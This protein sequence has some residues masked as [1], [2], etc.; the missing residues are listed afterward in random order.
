MRE[1]FG[2]SARKLSA[3]ALVVGGFVAISS[4]E[5]GAST[6]VSPYVINECGSLSFVT[7]CG[8]PQYV[9]NQLAT[10]EMNYVE[11]AYTW[12][13]TQQAAAFSHIVNDINTVSDS[14]PVSPR[15]RGLRSRAT[16]PRRS[17]TLT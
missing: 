1:T 15:L 17:C 11:T 12:T 6:G 16:F 10:D 9:A 3:I 5:S 2:R 7:V 13:A 8:T 14:A 4:G